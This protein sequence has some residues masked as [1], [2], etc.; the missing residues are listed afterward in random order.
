MKN[1][2]IPTASHPWPVLTVP[3]PMSEIM[4]KQMMTMLEAMKSAIVE[5]ETSENSSID[6][7]GD[8]NDV[9]LVIEPEDRK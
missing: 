6:K 5:E 4:W 2:E 1:I 9:D 8:A 3:F 7:D